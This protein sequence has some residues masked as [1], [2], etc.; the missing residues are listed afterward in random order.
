MISILHA[1]ILVMHVQTLLPS[2]HSQ[3]T[4]NREMPEDYIIKYT[5]Y[6]TKSQPLHKSLQNQ[7]QLS[8][9][10]ISKRNSDSM[11]IN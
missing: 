1:Q 2:K 6:P 3:A 7:A 9:V 4:Q 8:P 5:K 10:Q 11:I